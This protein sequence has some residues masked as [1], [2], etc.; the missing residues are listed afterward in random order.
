MT[1]A[2]KAAREQ[3]TAHKDYQEALRQLNAANIVGAPCS[4]IV[5]LAHIVNQAARRWARASDDMARIAR[6]P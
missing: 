4:E 2:Q 3:F 6:G 5:S 1:E